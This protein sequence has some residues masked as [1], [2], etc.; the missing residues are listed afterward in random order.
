MFKNYL[1]RLRYEY[2]TAQ[3]LV[4]FSRPVY[5]SAHFFIRWVQKKI[6]VNGK[7]VI[8]Q[9]V[10]IHFPKNVGINILSRIQW[11]KED[12][13]EPL[14]ART[15]IPLFK[16]G[17]FYLDIG[18]NFG[19][20]SV[21]AQKLNDRI[22]VICFEPLPNIFQD[23]LKF[24][25]KNGT[26]NQRTENVAISNTLGEVKFYVP[27][28]SLAESE[29]TSASLESNFFYNKQFEQK[30][31]TVNCKTL[32]SLPADEV[33]KWKEK[34]LILKIDV[35]GHERSVLEGGLQFF[36]TMRPWTV[37]EIDKD[38][39][40]LALIYPILTSLRYNAYG[41]TQVGYF[42]L[43]L[44]S[45]LDFKGGRDFLLIPQELSKGIDYYS[46]DTFQKLNGQ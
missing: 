11:Q 39:R 10:K 38:P 24:H 4:F 20:Y 8:Y 21:L 30:Q 35:E 43:S 14:T 36:D 2:F 17:D 15:L 19:F 31:I 7:S 27:D 26:V 18:S 22:G 3:I 42:K 6:K 13:F 44:Q 33:N 25:A 5:R 46:F 37:M 34:K 41:I 32:D 12:G 45:F 1:S 40:N 28:I 9:G 23:N 29:I 16:T